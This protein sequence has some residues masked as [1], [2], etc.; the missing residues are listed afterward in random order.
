VTAGPWLHTYGAGGTTA[1]CL[2]IFPHGGGSASYYRSLALSMAH[3]AEIHIVQYPGR[4]DRLAEAPIGEMADLVA[5]ITA[6]LVPLC[7]RELILFGHSMGASVAHEVARLLAR[8]Y[9]RR[10]ALLVVSARPGPA[11]QASGTT[12]LDDAALWADLRALNGT[13]AR[14][15]DSDA[16]RELLL[17]VLR[18]DYRLI[19]TYRAP[20]ARDLDIP[21]AACM[22]ADDPEVDVEAARAWRNVTTGEFAL[23]VFEG[24]H[25]FLAG[26]G[27]EAL[28]DWLIGLLKTVSDKGVH[29]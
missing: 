24:G 23:R 12:Y 19:E 14:L 20:L 17:P 10:A 6:A 16:L 5:A 28:R 8:V 11:A 13:D 15:L 7:D 21:V 18:S 2:I 29:R 1:P 25:F 4:E 22:G 27:R 3:A 9:R 26:P